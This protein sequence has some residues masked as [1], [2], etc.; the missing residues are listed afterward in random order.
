MT[1][2]SLLPL[3]SGDL[4]VTATRLEA[5]ARYPT[6]RSALR[7][8]GPDLALKAECET[9]GTGLV[10]GLGLLADGSLLAL[11]P[12]ARQVARFGADGRRL[13]DPD[14]GGHPF[15]SVVALP[16][17]ELLL[18][19]HLCGAAGP[20]AGTGRVHRVTSGFRPLRTYATA[21]NGGVSGFLGVTHMALAP[22]GV[23]LWHLSET[24]PLLYAH[25]LEED[26]RLGAVFTAT[27]PP[28]ML[29]GL[30]AIPGGDLLVANGSG[31]L[32]LSGPPDALRLLD[33]IPLP[34]PASGRPGWA[35][36]VL[37]PSGTSV[38][39]L[40]FLGGRLAEVA[41]A[42]HEVT[43]LLDLGLGS[44]LASLV[45]VP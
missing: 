40:D 11:D 44:S 3:A 38:F 39:A 7:L 43:R 20:F 12:Q 42:T 18:G 34:A 33:R 5:G 36:V 31:L 25:D 30:A 28:A 2:R 4:V 8:L 13:P 37:R 16:S 19:E 45:E 22:D 41:L 10:A 15:G 29:F 24:G 6:G 35:N 21:W 17:G 9:G 1:D 32:R 27:D 26:R 14:L 23:T